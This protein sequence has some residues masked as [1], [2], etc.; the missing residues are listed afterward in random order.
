MNTRKIS[1][2]NYVRIAV[3]SYAIHEI[4]KLNKL[5]NPWYSGGFRWEAIN[6]VLTILLIHFVTMS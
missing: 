6:T 1:N 3:G 4:F 2:I 5:L